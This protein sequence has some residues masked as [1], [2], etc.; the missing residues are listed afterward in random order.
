MISLGKMLRNYRRKLKVNYILPNLNTPSKL[1]EVPD[2]YNTIMKSEDWVE[3][4][5]YTTTEAY[6]VLISHL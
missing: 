2:L 4:V 5:K 6:K 3:Y 1:N